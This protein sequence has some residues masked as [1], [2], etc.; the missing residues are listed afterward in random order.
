MVKANI[1]SEDTSMPPA[2]ER[3]LQGSIP[4]H[5]G[6]M[7]VDGVVKRSK[8]TYAFGDTES[9]AIQ[10]AEK[11]SNVFFTSCAADGNATCGF[12]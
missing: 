3:H 4:D 10:E 8:G 7:I 1:D 5:L 6:H 11:A 2:P 12:L 9:S